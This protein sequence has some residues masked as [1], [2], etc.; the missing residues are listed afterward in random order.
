[1]WTNNLGN[2]FCYPITNC[3]YNLKSKNLFFVTEEKK[4]GWATNGKC[5]RVA[6]DILGS[7]SG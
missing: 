4:R 2:F 3:C 5:F 6:P 7:W 1:M